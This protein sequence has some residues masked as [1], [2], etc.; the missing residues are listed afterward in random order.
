M[1][2]AAE[3]VETIVVGGGQA[4]LSVGYHLARRGLP[5]VILEAGDAD[6]RRVAHALGLAAPVHARP[7][8]RPGRDAVPRAAPLRSRARTRWPTT[9]RRTRRASSCRSGPACAST[10]LSRNG[11]RLRGRGGRR[12][13]EADN[14]VVAIGELPAPA[15]AGVRRASSTRASC[16]CTPA[17]T[18]TR[19]SS[20]TAAC[21]SS[22]PATPAPRSRSSWPAR[23][24]GLAVGPRR[25]PRPVPHRRRSRPAS[26]CR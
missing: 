26:C 4:G 8:R 14:V 1:R 11:T 6:R 19:R 3:R 24:S 12:R 13:F 9:S 15:R 5:F 21:W 16:S 18:A 20:G 10:A 17:S 7:L 22:A 2:S 25:R 23:P